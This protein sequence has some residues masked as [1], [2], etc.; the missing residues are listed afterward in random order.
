MYSQNVLTSWNQKTFYMPEPQDIN[1]VFLDAVS[2]RMTSVKTAIDS[3]VIALAIKNG[4]ERA[5][6]FS[7]FAEEV[8]MLK[9]ILPSSVIPQWADPAIEISRNVV[10][11]FQNNQDATN[12]LR[13]L[14]K[15]LFP[16]ILTHSWDFKLGPSTV[17]D[18][19]PL[20]EKFRSEC[21]LDDLF[22]KLILAV[23]RILDESEFDGRRAEKE[24]QR[25][26]EALR[27]ANGGKSYVQ[28]VFSLHFAGSWLKHSSKEF[29]NKSAL[30]PLF[31]GFEKAL[32]ETQAGMDAVTFKVSEAANKEM[33][34]EVPHL[35]S[36]WQQLRIN[37]ESQGSE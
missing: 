1:K 11:S 20:Y 18:F 28:S 15:D 8:A 23:E 2:K 32:E 26:L 21:N 13:P 36:N 37:Y 6:P 22:D 30:G 33:K 34:A 19:E 3:I 12:Y 27:K 4:P 5:K 25:I 14:L 24:L 29:A 17:F 10:V 35:K 31:K 9:E 7:V 16:R